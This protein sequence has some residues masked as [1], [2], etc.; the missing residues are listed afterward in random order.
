MNNAN[1]CIEFF[2]SFSATIDVKRNIFDLC[3]DTK[4][5]YLAVIEVCCAFFHLYFF[6]MVLYIY[7]HQLCVFVLL[8]LR[9]FLLCLMTVN[10][11]ILSEVNSAKLNLNNEMST[12][13]IYLV[14]HKLLLC[15][16]VCNR[17]RTP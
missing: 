14:R 9:F 11:M 8:K 17:I 10:K 15:V 3:T 12:A 6:C 2:F 4:D 5:C 16:N 7:L 13:C 1:N